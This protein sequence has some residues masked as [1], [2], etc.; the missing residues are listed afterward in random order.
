LSLELFGLS[1]ANFGNNGITLEILDN[2]LAGQKD[3]GVLLFISGHLPPEIPELAMMEKEMGKA[4][5]DLG[6]QPLDPGK[7][8]EGVFI[9]LLHNRHYISQDLHFKL[10]CCIISISG[11]QHVP[12]YS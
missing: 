6:D 7:S 9:D 10:D 1:L 4:K 11:N 3:A 5:I 2:G 8:L 12:Q